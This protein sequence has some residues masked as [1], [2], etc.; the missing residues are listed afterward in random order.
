MSPAQ[1]RQLQFQKPPPLW[2]L[3]VAIKWNAAKQEIRI[4]QA[5]D[6]GAIKAAK[7]L[8]TEMVRLILDTPKTGRITKITF[9]RRLKSGNR[10]VRNIKRA[11]APGEAPASQTGKLV[12][13]IQVIS[14]RV[15][16]AL[17]RI[18]APYARFLERGTRRMEPRPFIRPAIVNVKAAMHAAMAETV[19]GVFRR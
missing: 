18:S 10:V 8:K 14:N 15:V 12:R 11:S 1:F 16:G 19:R 5:A 7:I 6:K 9:G 17:V 4:R 13:S 2:S 3:E